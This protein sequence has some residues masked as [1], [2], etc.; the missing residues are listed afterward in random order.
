MD[1]ENKSINDEINDEAKKNIHIYSGIQSNFLVLTSLILDLKIDHTYKFHASQYFTTG[2]FWIE[3]AICKY[4]ED[5]GY[6]IN[7]KEYFLK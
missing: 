2:M 3:K 6:E 7:K 5:K 4:L 1:E